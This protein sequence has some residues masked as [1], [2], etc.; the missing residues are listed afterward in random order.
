MGAPK[1]REGLA[2]QVLQ[3]VVQAQ[4]GAVQGQA[5]GE[6]VG[7]GPPGVAAPPRAS[8]VPSGRAAA[9]RPWRAW[10]SLPADWKLPAAVEGGTTVSWPGVGWEVMMLPLMATQLSET[11]PAT[12][13]VK[14]TAAPV[15]VAAPPWKVAPVRVQR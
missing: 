2:A 6:A 3:F 12:I 14:L 4:G 13:G 1:V 15:A 7:P 9:A 8:T 5:P 11:G 10:F